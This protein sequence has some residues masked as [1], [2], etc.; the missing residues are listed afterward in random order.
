MEVVNAPKHKNFE[1]H[2]I[3]GLRKS[4]FLTGI[5]KTIIAHHR[6]SSSF[7]MKTAIDNRRVGWISIM[8]PL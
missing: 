4:K 1:A 3:P 6:E 5:P 7:F 2:T 8:M